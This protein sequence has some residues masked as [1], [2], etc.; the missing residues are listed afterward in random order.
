MDFTVH[1][2]PQKKQLWVGSFIL[3]GCLVSPKLFL[4]NNSIVIP[5]VTIA[6]VMQVISSLKNSS[7]GWDEFP[8]LAAKQSLDSHIEP[9]TC[10]INRYFREGIFPTELKLAKKFCQKIYFLCKNNS[11][12]KNISM[13]IVKLH[14]Q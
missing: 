1:P 12:A 6:E 13:C 14:Q 2:S 5:P 10:L 11:I 3:H 7:T 8:A 9:L 4:K